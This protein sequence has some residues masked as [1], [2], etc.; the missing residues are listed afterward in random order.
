MLHCVHQQVDDGLDLF[1]G[2]VVRYGI[3]E[4]LRLRMARDG[5]A[6]VAFGFG[7]T[8]LRLVIEGPEVAARR[9]M[10]GVKIGTA[11][12]ARPWG[13][14]FAWG[15]DSW[16]SVAE[17][18]LTESIAW[19]HMAPV[20][21]GAAGPLASP[22]SSH[23]DVM[24]YRIADFYDPSVVRGRVNPLVV[25][26]LAGGLGVPAG[27]PPDHPRRESLELL[28][29]VAAGV[30]GVMPADRRCFRLFVH[31]GRARGW[32]TCDLARALAL[33]GRRVRQLAVEPED[34]LLVALR[35]LGDPRLCRVP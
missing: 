31:L 35:S 25:H 22:W 1:T 14:P 28:L 6:M 29:R 2:A 18:E 8:D 20:E 24:G 33:T 10:K 21:S 17:A 12:I 9:A 27:W 32:N 26:R 19:A 15:G 30:L 16:R 13:L 7:A 23:R 11:R 34:R 4:R 5:L 3:L